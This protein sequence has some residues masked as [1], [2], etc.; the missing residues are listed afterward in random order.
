V[1]R[2][3]PTT[4]PGTAQWRG[5]V[6]NP[7]GRLRLPLPRDRE[8]PFFL[9]RE[10]SCGLLQR[11]EPTLSDVTCPPDRARYNNT[12]FYKACGEGVAAVPLR[13]AP[14][15]LAQISS[16]CG[17][18]IMQNEVL[19]RTVAA[20]LRTDFLRLVQN[21]RASLGP[22]VGPRG[23]TAYSPP[24]ATRPCTG[25]RLYPRGVL[26]KRDVP[27]AHTAMGPATSRRQ[28]TR[29]EMDGGDGRWSR[30]SV[31]ARAPDGNIPA[32]LLRTQSMGGAL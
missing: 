11:A 8:D 7:V 13:V 18:F 14:H 16:F 23:R 5:A 17:P 21:N 9:P 12:R 30:S 4:F 15:E 28:E 29:G 25:W 22:G 20:A 32:G 3:G 6:L 10:R 2:V 27:R 19:W 1:E 26:G 24:P 31:V